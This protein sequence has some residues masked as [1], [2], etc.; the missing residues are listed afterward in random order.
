MAKN[1]NQQL[2]SALRSNQ[3]FIQFQNQALQEAQQKINDFQ[4]A[5][6]KAEDDRANLLKEL[7]VIKVM[8][9]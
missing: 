2:V 9:A 7:Q 5:Q 8:T 4:S 1:I 3:V 6:K